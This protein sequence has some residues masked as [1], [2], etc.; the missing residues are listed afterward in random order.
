MAILL[1]QNEKEARKQAI[2]DYLDDLSLELV[3]KM[4]DIN[5]KIEGKLEELFS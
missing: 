5:D 2:D 3:Q 1:N 4:E